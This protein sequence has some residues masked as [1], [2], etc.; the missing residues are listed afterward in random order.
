[1]RILEKKLR[2][3]V[4][5][6]KLL[7]ESLD[8]LWHLKYI[9][10]PGDLIHAL[11]YR[12]VEEA[13]DKIR[14]E[15]RE[16]KP[17]YLAIRVEEV[18]FHKFSNRLRIHGIIEEG[19]D[20]GSY[21]TLNIEPGSDLTVS[22]SWQTDQLDRLRDAVEASSRLNVVVLTIE[23]GHAACGKLREFGVEELF[24]YAGSRRKGDYADKKGG[25]FFA[26]VVDRLKRIQI[27]MD[28]LIVAGP[29]FVKD[30]FVSHLKAQYQEL[31]SKLIVVDTQSTGPSGYQEVLR[32][33][34]SGVLEIASSFRIAE[35]AELIEEL[36]REISVEGKAGYGFDEVRGK[37]EIGAVRT[38]LILDELLREERIGGDKE[39]DELIGLVENTGGRVVIFSS[40][41]EPGKRLKGLGGVGAVLRY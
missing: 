7:V 5:D 33:G 14:S 18:E 38:L 19:E 36:L 23:E 4:G 26:E 27:E 40:E 21:H 28:L 20:S 3:E 2:R 10:E 1:M 31:G 35:E 37:A 11:T 13:T 22:K 41:F 24:T 8:D 15:K 17:V 9:I 30:D 16:K 12:R 34:K 6:I 32:K 29:G 25:G 39:L